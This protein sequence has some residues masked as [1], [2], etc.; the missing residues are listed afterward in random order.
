MTWKKTTNLPPGKLGYNKGWNKVPK[1]KKEIILDALPG[2]N[3]LVYSLL[4]LFI[5][6]GLPWLTKFFLNTN[7]SD[8]WII[9][10]LFLLILGTPSWMSYKYKKDTGK[11]IF[12]ELRDYD[13]NTE[14]EI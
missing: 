9:L 6:Y 12:K 13:Q 8:W 14:K 10:S 5:V 2:G 1:G 7:I 4:V 3:V 11:D